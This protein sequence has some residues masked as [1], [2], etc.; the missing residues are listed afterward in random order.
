[1]SFPSGVRVAVMM[2]ASSSDLYKALVGDR[3]A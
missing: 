3:K 2:N 1:M